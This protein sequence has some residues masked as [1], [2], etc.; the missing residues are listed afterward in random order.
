MPPGNDSQVAELVEAA[1]KMTDRTAKLHQEIEVLKGDLRNDLNTL[2]TT[3]QEMKKGLVSPDPDVLKRAVEEIMADRQKEEVSSGLLYPHEQAMISVVPDPWAEEGSYLDLTD[4]DVKHLVGMGTAGLDLA[5]QAQPE[6]DAHKHFARIAMDVKLL[7]AMARLSSA[8]K[9]EPYPGFGAAL[10]KFSKRWAQYQDRFFGSLVGKA[11]AD[12]H[13]KVDTIDWVPTGWSTELRTLVT[14]ALK[15]MAFFTRIP[16]PQDPF[17]IPLDLTD[18]EADYMPETTSV[19]TSY[20]GDTNWQKLAPSKLTL[21]AAKLRS[22][23]FGSAEMTEDAMVAMLP[24]FRSQAVKFLANGQEKAGINGQKTGTI[25][26][27]DAPGAN[28]CRKAWDGLRYFVESIAGTAGYV[29]GATF[30]ST[31]ILITSIRKEMGEFGADPSDLAYIPSISAFLQMLSFS[32]VKKLNE[33]GPNHTTARG[34]LANVGGASIIPSRYVRQDLN[35]SGIYDGV[36]ETKTI[37][38]C[39]HKGGWIIGDKRNVTVDVV[40]HIPEDIYELVAFQRMQLKP[41]YPNTY[42][43]TAIIRNITS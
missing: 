10:P 14:L 7:D 13:D 29:D 21:E 37:V 28:D 8:H 16:M 17:T 9:G 26:T 1:G 2:T 42:I 27:G 19:P 34:E 39:V 35:A 25:D 40:K 22:R 5:V 4:Y 32:E 6:S 33:Y 12:L 30:N 36:T 24:L 15:V 20:P 43:H 11:A 31:D 3:V 41:V 23:L 18:T 38:I